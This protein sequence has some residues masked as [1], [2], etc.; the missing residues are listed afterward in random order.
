MRA[1][2]TDTHFSSYPSIN[3]VLSLKEISMV[4]VN[5]RIAD[6]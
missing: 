2:L 5:R 3:F 6:V 4:I 1:G